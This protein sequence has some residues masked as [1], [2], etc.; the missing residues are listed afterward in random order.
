MAAMNRTPEI[1]ATHAR[2]TWLAVSQHEVRGAYQFVVVNCQNGGNAPVARDLQYGRREP[3]VDVVTVYY[4]GA[5]LVDQRIKSHG[6]PMAMDYLP[7]RLQLLEGGRGMDVNASREKSR[8]VIGRVGR[9]DSRE[10]NDADAPIG[11]RLHVIEHDALASAAQ[12]EIVV[13]Y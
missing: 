6:G 11:Q 2:V 5:G 3:A 7:R 8:V 12:V 1:P 9:I 4:V 10:R 13:C